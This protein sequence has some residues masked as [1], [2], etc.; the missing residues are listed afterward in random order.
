[1][2]GSAG[3]AVT[4]GGERAHAAYESAPFQAP[5]DLRHC[6]A[7]ARRRCRSRRV[8]GG[9]AGTERRA[10][11]DGEA[12]ASVEGHAR[13]Q[14]SLGEGGE[15]ATRG[16]P[17]GRRAREPIPPGEPEH[18]APAARAP[19][20]RT[21]AARTN[22][23][24]ISLPAPSG[25]FHRFALVE[26][27]IMAPGLARKHPEIKAYRG[28]GIT[29]RTA[30][31]HADLSPLGFHASVRSSYGAWYID[32]YFV[33]RNPGVHASYYGRDAKYT[34]GPFVERES[35]LAELSAD[36]AYY[37]ASDTVSLHG[38]GFAENAAITVTIS[39]PTEDAATLT[40]T[41]TSD[42]QARSTRAS[43]P[44]RT[45]S[46]TCASSKRRTAPRAPT[47]A[48]RSSATTIPSVDPPTG[49]EPA[50][51]A[52]RSSPTRFRVLRRAGQRHGGQGRPD[53][54]RQPGLRGRPTIRMQF[55]ANNDL[56]T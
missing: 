39:D 15:A 38:G 2:G 26:Y 18:R 10:E 12:S 48:T 25:S 54:P 3:K 56:L 13:H 41:A 28:R 5:G 24:V 52:W 11:P 1:M 22:P 44:I 23:L 34:H 51:T 50:R 6:R 7:G 19:R 29:D 9:R 47:R 46:S 55:I 21:T 33:G 4:A 14:A 43:W 36:K 40:I 49:P 53:E 8:R 37:H 20:E 30:T 32:P 35:H 16:R 31:I 42:G 45:G 17:Q 27:P